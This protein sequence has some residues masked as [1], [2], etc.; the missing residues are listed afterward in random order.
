MLLKYKNNAYFEVI[1]CIHFIHSPFP[2]IHFALPQSTK[3]SES[4]LFDNWINTDF[5]YKRN[6][7]FLIARTQKPIVIRIYNYYPVTMESFL[8]VS[9]FF[10][11]CFMINIIIIIKK[12]YK[13]AL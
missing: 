6:L 4:V 5:E 7:M 10:L 11:N 12:L 1:I 2:A 9:G 13:K 3:L 8:A